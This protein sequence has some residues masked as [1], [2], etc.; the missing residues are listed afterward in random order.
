MLREIRDLPKTTQL[1]NAEA[2]TE[3]RVHSSSKAKSSWQHSEP[4]TTG[5]GSSLDESGVGSE[6]LIPTAEW[7]QLHLKAGS[8]HD[9]HSKSVYCKRKN[10]WRTDSFPKLEGLVW[11]H[12]P[13]ILS[14]PRVILSKPV[15]SGILI[16]NLELSP[17]IRASGRY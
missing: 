16:E 5:G 15:A 2:A 12:S 11:N 10:I 13:S 3:R 9:K 1:I 6:P 17:C 4:D 8:L 14:L 7:E